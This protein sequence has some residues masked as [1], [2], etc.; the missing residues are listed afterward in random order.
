MATLKRALAH[1][2][3]STGHQKVTLQSAQKPSIINVKHKTGKHIP[4]EI[5]YEESSVGECNANG[6]IE[7]ANQTIQRQIRAVKDC[8]ERQIGATTSLNSTVLTWLARHAAW[9]L[10]TFHVGGDGMTAHQRIRG[11][12][13]NQQIAAFGE[14]IFF[15][16]GHCRNSL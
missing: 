7:R 5:L 4:T 15:N 2:V 13:L 8:T 16:R 1:N 12:P 9:T 11:K 10:T 6:S 3:L 14:Q